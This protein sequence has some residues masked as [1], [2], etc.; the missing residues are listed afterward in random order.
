MKDFSFL[1]EPDVKKQIGPLRDVG[2][3]AAYKLTKRSDFLSAFEGV[4]S[5]IGDEI[6]GGA[7]LIRNIGCYHK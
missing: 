5:V 7:A 3:F 1:L 2:L 6:S 4:K